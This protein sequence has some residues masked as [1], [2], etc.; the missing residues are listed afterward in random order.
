M[1]KKV[2]SARIVSGGRLQIPAE[3]RRELRLVYGDSVRMAL[4][5]GELRV[6]S[7]RDVFKRISEQIRKYVPEG[8]SLADELI[9]ERRAEAVRE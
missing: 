4:V 6:R 9:E 2:H 3:V 7:T 1:S 8:V 5:D